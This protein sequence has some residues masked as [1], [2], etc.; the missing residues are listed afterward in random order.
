MLKSYKYRLYPTVQQAEL[1][2]KHIGACRFV[3]NLALE[4]KNYAYTTQRKN[5]SCFELICQLT[6]L[7]DECQWLREAPPTQSI[8][9]RCKNK[10]KVKFT[11]EWE[12]Q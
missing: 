7:K 8:C 6:S 11:D 10:F 1:I 2:R 3:Y 12:R 4:V 9:N 5:V